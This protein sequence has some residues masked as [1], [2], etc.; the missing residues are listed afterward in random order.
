MITSQGHIECRS[1]G[2]RRISNPQLGEELTI[3]YADDLGAGRAV[4]SH[5]NGYI[6]IKINSHN[7]IAIGVAVL[8][9]M[10]ENV[11]VALAVTVRVERASPNVRLAMPGSII[12][13]P[14][15]RT[16]PL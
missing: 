3:V 1:R 5:G 11:V 16:T 8:T 7:D 2:G 15:I 6:G 10:A 14:D 9:A 12:T 13:S 4:D